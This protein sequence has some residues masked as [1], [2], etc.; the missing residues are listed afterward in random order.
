MKLENRI[1]YLKDNLFKHFNLET[2]ILHDGK[3]H[4]VAI[5]CPGGG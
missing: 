2:Y 1:R 3:R 5:L 4:P